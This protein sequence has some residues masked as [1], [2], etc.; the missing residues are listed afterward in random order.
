VQSCFQQKICIRSHP[1]HCKKQGEGPMDL[2]LTLLFKN[3]VISRYF[4]QGHKV[5]HKEYC[6]DLALG[7]ILSLGL[8]VV[9][10]VDPLTM[11]RT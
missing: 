3:S 2:S 6:T 1:F 4:S 10:P 7:S 8:D 11:G 5:H 9:Q